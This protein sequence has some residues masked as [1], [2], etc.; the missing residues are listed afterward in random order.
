MQQIPKYEENIKELKRQNE[1]QQNKL[2]VYEKLLRENKA[3]EESPKPPPQVSLTSPDLFS[4]NYQTMFSHRHG[5]SFL[6]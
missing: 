6:C 4:S 1:D 3:E 2:N 5:Q